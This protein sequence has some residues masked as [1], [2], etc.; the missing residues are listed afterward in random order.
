MAMIKCRE[1][2]QS[3]S[4]KAAVCPYCGV[5]VRS[6]RKFWYLV[7]FVLFGMPLISMMFFKPSEPM[8][9]KTKASPEEISPHLWGYFGERAVKQRLKDPDSAKFQ[10]QF[11]GL[12]NIPCGEVNSKNSYG[13]YS[14]FQRYLTAQN[15]IVVFERDMP[16]AEFEKVWSEMCR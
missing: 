4:S 2:S 3:V 8:P 1:C 15:G 14:G 7:V 6:T 13:G 10:G 9:K 12:K 11:V 5:K 16:I